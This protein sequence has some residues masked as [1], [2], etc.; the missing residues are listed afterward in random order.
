M[1]SNAPLDHRTACIRGDTSPCATHHARADVRTYFDQSYALHELGTHPPSALL[2]P[3]CGPMWRFRHKFPQ[4]RRSAWT[5]LSVRRVVSPIR[6]RY[7]LL[8]Q[9]GRSRTT[10]GRVTAR[11]VGTAS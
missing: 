3:R 9:S 2:S 10:H 7:R 5:P 8:L 4:A 6:W 1:D 11:T